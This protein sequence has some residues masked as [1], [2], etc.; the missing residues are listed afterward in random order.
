MVSIVSIGV[1]LLVAVP[2]ALRSRRV[3][4]RWD[5]EVALVVPD[6]EALRRALERHA[7]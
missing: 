1:L 5:P 6:A 7:L 2:Y 4:A 3:T